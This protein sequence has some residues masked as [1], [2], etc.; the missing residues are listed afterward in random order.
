LIV[1]SERPW[2]VY[3]PSEVTVIQSSVFETSERRAASLAG[4]VTVRLRLR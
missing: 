1:E 3:V 2:I 4:S